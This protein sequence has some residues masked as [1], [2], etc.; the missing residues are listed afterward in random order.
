MLLCFAAGGEAN[1]DGDINMSSKYSLI[2]FI[3][4]IGSNTAC[5]HYVCHILKD[6]RWV[7]FNDE[8]VAISRKLPDDLGYMY[9]YKRDDL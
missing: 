6:G 4:H 2:A 3:S 8:K 9:L 5:G 1:L 7:L